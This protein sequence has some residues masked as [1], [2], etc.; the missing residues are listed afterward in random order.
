MAPFI[1]LIIILFVF[2]WVN[3]ALSQRRKPKKFSRIKSVYDT[4]KDDKEDPHPGEPIDPV[5]GNFYQ[6]Y[7][8]ATLLRNH[9]REEGDSLSPE[10]EA[11]CREIIAEIDN[12]RRD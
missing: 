8:V 9:L 12:S 4:K 3:Y 6:K 2:Y 1:F 7:K 10:Q 11:Y 5:P